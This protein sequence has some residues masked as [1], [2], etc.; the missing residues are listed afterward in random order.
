M[1]TPPLRD[2]IF[3]DDARL[4][5]YVEQIASSPTYDK[6]PVWSWGLSL[7]G[8]K[9]EGKQERKERP[10]STNEKINLLL[11]HLKKNDRLAHGRTQGPTY[12]DH[13]HLFRIET[14]QAVTVRMRSSNLMQSE[15]VDLVLWVSEALYKNPFHY[16]LNEESPEPH[17][18]FLL[19]GT[20]KG[21]DTSY[22]AKSAYSTLLQLY[23]EGVS[24]SREFD[25]KFMS[26]LRA[27]KQKGVL[28]KRRPKIFAPKGSSVF[29][30][31]FDEDRAE[32]I[33]QEVDEKLR[34]DSSIVNPRNEELKKEFATN[35]LGAFRRMGANLGDVQVIEALYR[36][37]A[38]YMET[39]EA[40]KPAA[41]ITFGYPIFVSIAGIPL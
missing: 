33:A 11:D 20:R 4:D 15:A 37:R 13:Q 28:Q 27:K 34:T 6:V 31:T 21:D 25:E 29:G 32:Q 38:V 18:L 19:K 12:F 41:I 24:L 1:D 30:G 14:C 23:E 5:S 7:T 39:Q 22:S 3:V 8:L 2:Y 10:R 9:V 26:D 40:E 35:P 17:R 36:V 16:S